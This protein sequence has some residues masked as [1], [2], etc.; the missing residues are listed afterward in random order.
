MAALK[1]APVAVALSLTASLA[2]PM[3]GGPATARPG[4]D[5]VTRIDACLAGAGNL[6][7]ACIGIVADA[8]LK[9]ADSTERMGDCE[10]RE[11]AVWE[12]WLKRDSIAAKARLKPPASTRFAEIQAAFEADT[13]RRCD[14]VAVLNGP[15][16]LNRPASEECA[17]HAA[18]EQWLWL[19]S[20]LP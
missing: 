14:F 12:A 3:F 11:R 19:R 18:A 9:M 4:H 5:D 17:L 16:T 8:C 7:S 2:S 10:A 1:A 13:A 15:T 6:S 20:V